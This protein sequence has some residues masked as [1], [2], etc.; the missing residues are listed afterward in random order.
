MILWDLQI[1]KLLLKHGANPLLK[2][3]NGETACD[4]NTDQFLQQLMEKNISGIS[5]IS[6]KRIDETAGKNFVTVLSK[7]LV[8]SLD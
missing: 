6:G 4:I 5:A 3:M 7:N 2:D 1:A 8:Q